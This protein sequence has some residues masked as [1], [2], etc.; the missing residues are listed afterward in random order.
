MVLGHTSGWLA[1]IHDSNLT[2][3]EMPH[4]QKYQQ[5]RILKRHF[6]L[7]TP[8]GNKG[9]ASELVGFCPAAPACTQPAVHSPREE[10]QMDRRVGAE[11]MDGAEE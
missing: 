8:A 5:N 9:C 1:Y 3:L 2:R 6:I 4:R 10:G 11:V 7:N